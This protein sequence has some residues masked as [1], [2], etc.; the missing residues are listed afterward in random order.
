MYRPSG[1][2]FAL[3]LCSLNRISSAGEAAISM[4]GA[5]DAALQHAPQI[6]SVEAERNAALAGVR[7]VRWGRFP[8]LSARSQWTRGDN[9]VY[10]FGSLLEQGRFNASHFAIDSLNNPSDLSHF[11]SALDL[12][13]PLFTGMELTSS[14]RRGELGVKQAENSRETAIQQLRLHVGQLS[15]QWLLH[16][17]L[18][19]NLAERLH[20]S[21]EEMKEA[22]KLRQRGLVLGSDYFAAEAILSGL[23]TWKI[24]IEVDRAILTERLKILCGRPS[25]EI[26]GH[27]TAA[28]YSVAELDT[29]R[30]EALTQRADVQA[31]SHYV[32]IAA[33][34]RAQAGR[35]FWPRV[36]A[37]ATLETET[38][39]FD[40]NPAHHVYGIQAHIPIGDPTYFARKSRARSSEQA[41]R[42]TYG[43][44]KDAVRS[45]VAEAFQ[46]Y[47]GALRQRDQTK[48]TVDSAA[49]SLDLFRPLYRS[50]RQ[51]ILEVLRAEEALARAQASYRESEFHVHA[52]Y[53]Q[54]RA[55]MGTLDARAVETV[56]HQLGV[57]L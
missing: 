55:V 11:K 9:P 17:A 4:S 14:L 37:F 57:S 42:Q 48:Q 23:Q 34:Q 49:K 43:S 56:T 5:I 15:L 33:V 27:L 16:T 40:S 41:A 22:Q 13:F 10:V 45:E 18:L 2:L 52:R 46:N 20:A 24:Q 26:A 19:E 51:S 21:G 54:L 47:Q 53:L 25:V 39:D 50:G 35:T 36:Q 7:E 8:Q 30:E 28:T 12:G 3:L 44:L 38:R 31:A 6:K 1:L 29:L 32:E